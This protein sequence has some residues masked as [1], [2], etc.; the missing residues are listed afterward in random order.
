MNDLISLSKLKELLGQDEDEKKKD[1]I[2]A[3]FAIV[4]V[5]AVIAL[6]AY[7]IYRFL[8]PKYLDDFEDDFEDD[9]DD[10]YF[11]DEEPVEG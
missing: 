4:G 5:I 2:I 3:V 7:A 9:F 1:I 8:T 11:D 10:D 6:V